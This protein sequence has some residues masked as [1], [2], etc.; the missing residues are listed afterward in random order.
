MSNFTVTYTPGYVWQDG[1]LWS[2]EKANLAANPTINVTGNPGSIVLGAGSVGITNLQSGMFTADVTGRAPFEPGWL[3]LS[4]IGNGIFT[5]DANGR[6]PFA[7]GW[8]TAALVAS[9]TFTATP[10]GRAA[11]A[12]GMVNAAMMQPDA[13][14]YATGGGTGSAY[15]AA[16][17]PALTSYVNNS[18]VQVFTAYWDGL[19]VMFKAPAKSVQGATLNVDA[20]GVKGIY[21]RDGTAVQAGDIVSGSI[22][23]VVY[24]ST[25]N[26]GGGGWQLLSVPN[27]VMQAGV[28]TI[29]GVSSVTVTLAY[30]MANTSYVVMLTPTVGYSSAN[31]F[32]ITVL[33]TTQFSVTYN[34]GVASGD[35]FGWLAIAQTQ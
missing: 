25:F 4:L 1:E 14:S 29:N 22:V 12:N 9:G 24:N 28:V 11:F 34:G 19:R 26:S 30:A 2:A 17:S 32:Y 3:A 18:G 21:R 15:T 27:P 8:L 33:S 13:Y 31:N 6:A 20:L 10:A 7:N 5:A 16:F 23:E 35:T